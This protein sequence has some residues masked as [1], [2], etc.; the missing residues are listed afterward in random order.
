[1]KTWMWICLAGL[2]AG[3]TLFLCRGTAGTQ[4]ADSSRAEIKEKPSSVSPGFVDPA[5]LTAKA[6][7]TFKAQFDTTKGKFT[8]EVTRALAPNG[9]DRFYN[10][11]RRGPRLH[12]PVRHPR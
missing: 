11:V 3:A 10:L 1:M 7:E 2:A 5:K 6:P 9:A 12:V 8:I 4:S